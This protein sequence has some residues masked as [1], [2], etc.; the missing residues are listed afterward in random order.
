MGPFFASTGGR[1]ALVFAALMVLAGS[2]VI[3]RIVTI[4][5]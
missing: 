1:I 2:F 4:K 3:K 5:V